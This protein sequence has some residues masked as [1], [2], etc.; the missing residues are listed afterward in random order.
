MVEKEIFENKPNKIRERENMTEILERKKQTNEHFQKKRKKKG[1]LQ[2]IF[3]V[4]SKYNLKIC[5]IFF[6]FVHMI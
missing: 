3:F 6:C 4:T 1:K 2:S 5:M